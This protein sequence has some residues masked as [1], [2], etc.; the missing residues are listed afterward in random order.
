MSIIG[1]YPYYVAQKNFR[2]AFEPKS[3]CQS[4]A[5]NFSQPGLSRKKVMPFSGVA[6]P[7][8]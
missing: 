8:S 3:R 5:R 2:S 4:R 1:R 6:R 7:S